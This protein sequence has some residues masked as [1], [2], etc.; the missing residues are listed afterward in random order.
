MQSLLCQK[1]ITKQKYVRVNVTKKWF[2]KECKDLRKDREKAFKRGDLQA[3]KLI[4][5]RFTAA[6]ERA[7]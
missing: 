7:K 4:G 5:S 2:N 3:S 6:C 1:G